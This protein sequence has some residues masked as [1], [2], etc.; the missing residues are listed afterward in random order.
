MKNKWN[1][2]RL[3]WSASPSVTPGDLF[4][5]RVLSCMTSIAASKMNEVGLVSVLCLLSAKA[6]GALKH[7][8]HLQ[9][10][11]NEAADHTAAHPPCTN[12]SREPFRGPRRTVL[13][14]ASAE[15][16][17]SC[18]FLMLILSLTTSGALY[19]PV[20]CAPLTSNYSFFSSA[21][22]SKQTEM[23]LT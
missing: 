21:L 23:Y 4:W 5:A 12:Q 7:R 15:M 1:T 18:V 17:P 6:A 20:V 16:A 14:H 22:L 2:L 10:E 8:E 19:F 9:T 3:S 13:F 11:S